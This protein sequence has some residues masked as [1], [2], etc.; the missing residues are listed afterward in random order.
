MGYSY[1]ATKTKR[2]NTRDKTNGFSGN[3]GPNNQRFFGWGH[4]GRGFAAGGCS[5]PQ[6]LT[7]GKDPGLKKAY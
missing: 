5:A 6:P 4:Q 3:Y 7:H 1:W 2:T